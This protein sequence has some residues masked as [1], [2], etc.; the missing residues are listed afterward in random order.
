MPHR[1]LNPRNHISGPVLRCLPDDREQQVA[2]VS[3]GFEPL[4]GERPALGL[5]LPGHVVQERLPLPEE[6]G[7]GINGLIGF[8]DRL[9][10]S[11]T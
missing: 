3:A 5:G 7:S 8:R 4:A 10:R 11:R 6:H 1:A 2:A 9:R